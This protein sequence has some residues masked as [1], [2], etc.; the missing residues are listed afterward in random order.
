MDCIGAPL[1]VQAA[2]SA[3]ARRGVLA[4]QI[5]SSGLP[6]LPSRERALADLAQNTLFEQAMLA[7]IHARLG[8]AKAAIRP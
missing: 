2:E 3:L 8:E 4:R 1:L 5:A 6:G 7:A